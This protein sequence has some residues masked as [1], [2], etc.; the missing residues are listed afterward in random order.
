MKRFLILLCLSAFIFG[1]EDGNELNRSSIAVEIQNKTNDLCD[2][3]ATFYLNRYERE[4]D[5]EMIKYLKKKIKAAKKEEH[6]KHGALIKKLTDSTSSDISD[7]L[8]DEITE[9]I[10]E[11]ISDALMDAFGDKKQ[12]AE[13]LEK[14]L[15]AASK[16][17]ICM[18]CS[19]VATAFVTALFTSGV[20]LI[21]HFTD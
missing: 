16:R 10:H 18:A 11:L 14:K 13:T 20:M 17:N 9:E 21:I 15:K 7:D 2:V 6:N 19:N 5:P 8:S 1:M 3:I 4:V 12:Q